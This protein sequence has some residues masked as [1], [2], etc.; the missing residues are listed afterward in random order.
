[1]QRTMSGLRAVCVVLTSLALTAFAV[2]SEPTPRDV[3]ALVDRVVRAQLEASAI[4]G[5]S[6]AVVL[7]GE[8]VV[9]RG[10]GSA[11]LATQRPADA[12]TLFRI[13]SV[14][15]LV[16]FTAVMQLV[17]QGRLDLDADI[18]GYLDFALPRTLAHHPFR[19]DPGPITLSHLLTHTAGFED[20]RGEQFF[21]DAAAVPELGASLRDRM[22]A[23]IFLPGEAVAYSSYG[24]ALAGY[25]VE[26]V[27][28]LPFARAVEE[29]V[30]A[31]LA[32][33]RSTF[34]Q[35]LPPD[36]VPHLARASRFVGDTFLEDRFVYVAGPPA[37]SMSTTATDMARF[38]LAHLRGGAGILEPA[39]VQ[40]MHA[41]AF[42]HHPRVD[43]MALGFVERTL[44]G[45][46]FLFHGGDIFSFQSGLFLL[47]EHD[48][49]LFVSYS[50]G[51]HGEPL[52]LFHEFVDEL[53]PGES[54][55]APA[56]AAGADRGRAFVGEYHAN[57]RSYSSEESL[58]GLMEAVHVRV[59]PDGFL[60]AS[61][62]GETTR[63]AEVEPGVFTAVRQG[64]STFPY[65]AL[66]TLVFRADDHGR[67]MLFTDGKVS[68]ARAPLLTTSGFTLLAIVGT[69]LFSLSTL[70]GWG[71]GFGVRRIRR[72]S[73]RQP[74]AA[75]LARWTAVVF[76]LSVL[77]SLVGA[78]SIAGGIDPIYGQP[79]AAFGIE[80]A[81]SPLLMVPSVLMIVAG[82]AVVPFAAVAWVRG[83]WSVAARVHYTALAA[84][85]LVFLPVLYYWNL[86]W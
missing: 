62:V 28:G 41:Q 79:L 37:G 80:P 4:P 73:T 7:D 76:T 55:V 78:A 9:A 81:W 38:M 5:A 44:N 25:I 51:G 57:R 23:R 66:N 68:Y 1:M 52:T 19:G 27:V 40:A 39:T 45:H 12:D 58:L 54:P 42:T 67:A 34:A 49:G 77:I 26:R 29:L 13:G 14:S 3:E 64:H 18:A 82:L 20:A 85:A 32:M 15:K 47:P 30:F 65:G 59:D 16:T 69:A 8:V 11:D 46:R 70:V 21:L 24:A 61:V 36:L 71:M 83:F 2:A 60:T 86:L 10:Y 75:R 43:G 6:V 84:V 22:P 63:F 35:P 53:F 31:P 72:T 33:D 48:V 17:E 50:G 56:P 74:V